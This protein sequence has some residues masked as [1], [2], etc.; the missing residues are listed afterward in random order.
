MQNVWHTES[1][2]DERASITCAAERPVEQCIYAIE[3]DAI[4]S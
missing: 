3:A 4:P 2:P 1:Y